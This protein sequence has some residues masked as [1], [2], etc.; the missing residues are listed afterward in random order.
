[1][2][3]QLEALITGLARR[4]HRVRVIARTCRLPE[5]AGVE[6]H[7][8]R[9]PGRPF[10]LAYPWFMIAGSLALRRRRAGLVQSTGSIVL[11][12][13]D[14]LAVHY[15][16]QVGPA[17]P[18]R[19]GP[20]YR[21]NV[22]VAGALKRLGERMCLRRGHVR[23][24]VCVSEGVAEE[25]RTHF[26]ELAGSV[27]TIHNGV[28]TALFAPGVRA[29]EAERRREELAIA[30]DDLVAAFVGSE[31][32][33]KGLGPAIGALAQAP[34]WTL[35]VAGGGDRAR[36]EQLVRELGVEGRVRWLGVTADV[37]L[38]YQLSDVFLLPSAYETFSLVTFEA[39]ACGLALLAAPVS[40]VRELI[41]DGRNG[42]LIDRDPARIAALLVR[43][44]EEPELRARLGAAARESALEYSWDRMVERHLELY[45][46]L[47][48]PGA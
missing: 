18:K 38:V 31:W 17:N 8:V 12:R 24:V 10:A 37:Q 27:R 28:D 46:E 43:L 19:S 11:N 48:A 6:F 23:A 14:V 35:V 39:A 2:E 13:V 34:G 45:R 21:A 4:G 30:K 42:F 9:A 26:P 16:H 41:D 44:G 20:A 25:V 29:A 47:G 33:R 36:Y 7:R 32:E 1:M 15:L 22:L 3:R 5:G 40:G